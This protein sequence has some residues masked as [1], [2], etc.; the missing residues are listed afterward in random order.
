[1]VSAKYSKHLENIIEK[2]LQLQELIEDKF[3]GLGRGQYGRVIKMARKP[4]YDEFMKTCAITGVGII[5]IGGLGFVIYLAWKYV[6]D[7]LG[8]LLGL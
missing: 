7:W 1:M 8:G 5:A 6:P 4:E 3:R 2:S